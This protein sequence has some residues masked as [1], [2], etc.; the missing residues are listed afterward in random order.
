[1]YDV[2]T[3]GSSTVDVFAKTEFMEEI[4]IMNKKEVTNLL[5]Y[6]IGSKILVNELIFSTGG[7]GTNTAVSL[8]RLG[9]KVA[10]L[11]VLGNDENAN[12]IVNDLSKEKVDILAYREKGLS[13]YS[14]ILDSLEHDRTILAYKGVNDYFNYNKVNLNK[15]KTNWFYFSSMMNDAFKSL[16]KLAKFAEKNK[17]KIAFNI[18][19]YLAKKGAYYLKDILSRT[20]LFVLNYEEAGYLIPSQ[21]IKE[22]LME[23][24]KLCPKIVVITDGHNDVNCYDGEF[25]YTGKN[26][27]IKAVETT[28]AGDA[29]ASSFLS[30]FIKKNDIE[31]AI[32]LGMTNAHSV[33]S[34]HGAKNKLLKWNE[35][36]AALKKNPIKVFKKRLK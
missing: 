8:A 12:F 16:V 29:F 33:I 30:G 27:D 4:K 28:G 20:D 5:A 26:R 21:D 6:P 32:K 35:A 18:S 2:I 22:R 3:V 36:L 23:L 17:I 1:M 24:H 25:W 11:G 9:N 13:G 31:F 19:E 7:G 10:W 15:L 34:C 14:L